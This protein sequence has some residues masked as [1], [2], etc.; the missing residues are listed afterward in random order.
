MEGNEIAWW[1][2]VNRAHK[3]PQGVKEDY[4]AN[5]GVEFQKNRGYRAIRP[6]KG[7]WKCEGP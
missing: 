1:G 2:G 5:S 6:R 3:E 7:T 4:R